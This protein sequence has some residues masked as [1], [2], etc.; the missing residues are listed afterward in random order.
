M[1]INIHLSVTLP[2]NEAEISGRLLT[3]EGTAQ[4]YKITPPSGEPPGEPRARTSNRDP[5][6]EEFPVDVE[7]S[8]T[9][10]GSTTISDVNGN[11]SETFNLTTPGKKIIKVK[12]KTRFHTSDVDTRYVIVESNPPE[13]KITEPSEGEEIVRPGPSYSV[14]IAGTATDQSGIM[15]VEYTVD[16]NDSHEVEKEEDSSD[17]NTW[18]WYKDISDLSLGEHTLRVKAIDQYKI[19]S[20]KSRTITFIET[21][22]PTVEIKSPEVSPHKITGAKDGVSVDF[23]GTASADPRDP[24]TNVQSVTWRLDGGTWR[25]EEDGYITNVSGDWSNW[26]FT[27]N[28]PGPG[29]H[30]IEVL[31]TNG[32]GKGNTDTVQID[33]A[34]P[35]EL[36]D[37]GFAA[38]LEDLITFTARRVCQSS[39]AEESID[40]KNIKRLL[41]NN[42]HQPFDRLTDND[43]QSITA[44]PV[45]QVR[46]AVE[47][48]RSF[49]GN[50][51]QFSEYCETA[52]RSLLANLGTSY[53]EIRLVRAADSE[54]RQTLASRLGIAE[55]GLDLLF[56]RPEQITET[57][58]QAVFGLIDTTQDPLA[59]AIE[60]SEILT[61]QLS[62]LHSSWLEQDKLNYANTEIPIPII[63]PDIIE[64]SDLKSPVSGNIAYDLFSIRQQW[65]SE[66]LQAIK[67]ERESQNTPLE[68]FKRVVNLVLGNDVDLVALE[69][70][71]QDGVDIEPQ[72]DAI[73]LG[74]TAFF[75]LFRIRKL[76]ETG[77]VL[78]LEWAELYNI[79]LQVKK[80]REFAA[81]SNE[82]M[83]KNLTL[84]LNF[85]T[86]RSTRPQLI[87]WRSS[88]RA[89]RD[90][91]K[92][93][94]AR[95]KQRGALIQA[96][97][98]AIDVTEEAV[99]PL[100]RDA[101]IDTIDRQGYPDMD[102]ADWLTQRL[103]I[104][105]KYS[106]N[107]KLT[108]LEQGIETL[109]DILL[110]LR[111]GRLN[112]LATLPVG[113]TVPKWKL[114]V[115]DNYN[116]YNFDEEWKWMGT[117]ATWRGA[118]FAFGYP[119]NY[120]LPTLR[121][122]T[123][124]TSAFKKLV[125]EIRKQF[126]ITPNKAEEL[127]QT[128]IKTLN[129]P[130]N[131]EEN[132]GDGIAYQI[133][134]TS[135]LTKEELRQRREKSKSELEPHI[136]PQRGG[137]KPNTPSHLKEVF[138][139]VPMLL[140]L[141]LQKRGQFLAALDWYQ[142]VY[143]YE[144]PPDERKIYYGLKAEEALPTEF[145]RTFS[146]LLD[147]LDVFDIAN[148]RANALTRFTLLSIVRCYLAFADAEFTRETNE[149]IPLARRLYITALKLLELLKV[150]SPVA[151][152]AF[153]RDEGTSAS[154]ITG[155]GHNATLKG[156][157]WEPNGWQS[158]AISFSGQNE[159]AEVPHAPALALGKDGGDFSV[160]FA[161]YLRANATRSWRQIMRKGA[162]H[163]GWERTPGIWLR[164]DNN[165]IHFRIS[166]TA[167]KNEGSDS[168]FAVELNK[169]THIAYVKQGKSL[170][171]YINGQLD[172][173]ISL[174]G[175]SKGFE[176]PLFIGGSTMNALFDDIRVYDRALNPDAVIALAGI[177]IFPPNPVVN[178]LNL[179]AELNLRKL[180]TGRNIAGMERIRT[181]PTAIELVAND[182][183]LV[184]PPAI[185]LK[186]TAYRYSALIERA[187]QLV[188]IAQQIEA[189]FFT[190]LEKRDVEAYNLLNA[191]QDVQLT[192]ETIE[193]Q[194]LRIQ[195]A[196][197]SI[198]LMELQEDRAQTQYNTYNTWIN[199]G[200]NQ[201]ERNMLKNYQD[202]KD[203]RN[204]LA[205]LEA[206]VTIAQ[207]AVDAFAAALGKDALA[208]AA[209]T[210]LGLVA[211]EK[212]S[213]AKDINKLEAEAQTNS[214]NANLERRKDEWT[215]QRSLVNQ[216]IDIAAQQIFQAQINK[217]IVEQE[218]AIASIQAKN[219]EA[220]VEFLNNKFTNVELYEW[221]SDILS[222]VYS[223][224]LQQAT[225]M[226]QLASNQLAFERQERP[227]AFIQSDYWQAPK[228]VATQNENQEEPDRRGITGSARLLQDI[229]QLDQHA[230]ETNKRKLQLVE[231][232]SLARLFPYE[233]QRFR[234]TGVLPFATPMSLF[235]R[236]F[237]G[238]YLRLIKRVRVSVVGLIPPTEGIRASLR[239]AGVSRVVIGNIVYRI[240]EVRRPSE[241]IAFTS[242]RNATGLFELQPENELLLPFE[243]MGV[244]ANWELQLPKAANR[245]NFDAIAD[246]IF[247]MEYTALH[248]EDYR[249]Q[250]IQELSRTFSAERAYS[251]RQ[252]FPDLWYDLHQPEALIDEN[253]GDIHAQ[254]TIEQ[255]HFPPNLQK[256]HI[257]HVVLYFVRTEDANFKICVKHLRCNQKKS[258]GSVE[259]QKDGVISTR[260][261]YGRNWLP[262][263]GQSPVGKWTLVFPNT[264]EFKGRFEDEQI[265]DILFVVSYSGETPPWPDFD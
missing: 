213:T 11:W 86:P 51:D 210:A 7:I 63:D 261:L 255:F 89:R 130:K 119:E 4:G 125:K 221:M 169:W 164:P 81:W 142:T 154:D 183:V 216:D 239:A 259:S 141:S 228:D 131:D 75:V 133:E 111:T 244:D 72:L 252:D 186:P 168:N 102:L 52:Y 32:A 194:D 105:F 84:E 222:E 177:D 138:F 129:A 185:S 227:P 127:A 134:L 250:V 97:Q 128:Y 41:T 77:V 54:T 50:S 124:W 193:L 26:R 28:I 21:G 160:T 258:D 146:W 139:F 155:N 253:S 31:A 57:K 208:A 3:V 148:D 49:L 135:Q 217:Q 87:P 1:T 147:G 88:W 65:V 238:H 207:T 245:F 16:N 190:A 150:P 151:H 132:S 23:A 56:L 188:T 107:Q 149:S 246:V 136:D 237:P 236:G 257:E 189:N 199:T 114:A 152:W 60:R 170:K 206:S 45:G 73:P 195:E 126:R 166:T 99:L 83:S 10:A 143:A 247:T 15:A 70:E 34:V 264:Q 29:L 58:L 172:Q 20:I 43:L 137:L 30:N 33:V 35:F 209:A 235:D 165:R 223:Y 175:D 251:F 176:A 197:I 174:T 191:Q 192:K 40:A 181:E 178:A 37:L 24:T 18:N 234:E 62:K 158:G 202:L 184:P 76:A 248:S 59:L 6:V 215:L 80:Q 201:Y 67:Q 48:L 53:S 159:Y 90:W 230:F 55:I 79:L 44:K 162:G 100:L 144:L 167:N 8:V 91:E 157:Q 163:D 262:L 263:V 122:K 187:K 219:A 117:Y 22:P 74:M 182:G 120:L 214:F 218:R 12:A 25:T 112:S 109:Q 110:A 98:A 145:R 61:M 71:Y 19:I 103:S 220:E 42:F 2:R 198:A 64:D 47:V 104:S 242:P 68:G 82:E 96:H 205:D 101:L 93:L 224:F 256:L 39:N 225:A 36:E 204:S 241:M 13:L 69:Q 179:H 249:R 116:E 17:E 260:R 115:G 232:F 156:G 78:D 108:R 113:T 173:E 212:A 233:F 200:S 243:T 14:R 123:E 153:D 229:Y 140:A 203:K 196:D 240:T 180:R 226:A 66:Q 94:D 121:D 27:A 118:M 95:I 92:K 254:F 161:F 85:F 265:S 211:Y 106:G 46:I 231:N 5:N 38:Y 9:G 171:L